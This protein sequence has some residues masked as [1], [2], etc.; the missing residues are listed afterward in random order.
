MVTPTHFR[1]RPAHSHAHTNTHTHT[2]THIPTLMYIHS[3]T[4]IHRFR[5]TDTHSDIHIH[6]YFDSR[7][8]TL[9][10]EGPMKLL[11][12]LVTS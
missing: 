6:K 7:P 3:G 5:D 10:V 9:V 11:L 12:L 2:H 4:L 8:S 1:H